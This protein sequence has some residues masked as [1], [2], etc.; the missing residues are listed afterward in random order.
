MRLKTEGCSLPF[1]SLA[2][3]V[4]VL[5]SFTDAHSALIAVQPANGMLIGIDEAAGTQQPLYPLVA[6]L[7]LVAGLHP[8]AR[9]APPEK[10]NPSFSGLCPPQ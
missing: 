8:C 3:A 7:R 4:M 9:S 6:P 10:L 5:C 2:C 1:V